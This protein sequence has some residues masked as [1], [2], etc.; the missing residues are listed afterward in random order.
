MGMAD[1]ALDARKTISIDG[2]TVVLSA[3][4]DMDELQHVVQEAVDHHRFVQI[5]AANGTDLRVLMSA[6][7]RVTIAVVPP[8]AVPE[9]QPYADVDVEVDVDVGTIGLFDL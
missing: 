7:R 9:E 8:W 3:T 1:S 2:A 6:D 5:I 4:E